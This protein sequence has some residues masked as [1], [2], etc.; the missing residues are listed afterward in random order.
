MLPYIEIDIRH[1]RLRLI[2]ADGTEEFSISTAAKGVGELFGSECTPRGKHIIRAKIGTGEPENTVFIGRRPIGE[3]YTPELACQFPQRD[4]ILTRILWL[5]GL[6]P[7]CNRLGKVDTMRRYI[8]IH[9]CPDKD[10]LG[11]PSSHGCIKMRNRDI[12]YL[13]ERVAC[14]MQVNINE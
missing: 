8:Y 5:S 1:Q 3:I 12:I 6:E 2:E 4:W 13:F 14:G 9:A 11:V 7:G 10:R